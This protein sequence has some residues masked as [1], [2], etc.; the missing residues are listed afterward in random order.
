[1]AG[2]HDDRESRRAHDLASDDA[3]ERP[4][5]PRVAPGKLSRSVAVYGLISRAPDSAAPV[6]PDPQRID[7]AAR[8][9]GQAL[10]DALRGELE[11]SIGA[12]LSAVRV[13]TDA[14]SADAAQSIHAKA[15]TTGSD[16][17]FAPSSYDPDSDAGRRLIAHEVAHTVQQ[18]G[19]PAVQAKL[20]VSQPGDSLELEAD[21]F[22]DAFAAGHVSPVQPSSGA[23]AISRA[24]V[25]G[26]GVLPPEE[27]DPELALYLPPPPA[28]DPLAEPSG[29]G[30]PGPR[31][32]NQLGLSDA[33]M[34]AA[35]TALAPL[36]DAS[37]IDAGNQ[38]GR[39]GQRTSPAGETDAPSTGSGTT[40]GNAP[41]TAETEIAT[42]QVLIDRSVT[43]AKYVRRALQIRIAQGAAAVYGVD[44][45]TTLAYAAL[46]DAASAAGLWQPQHLRVA[47]T[48]APGEGLLR[49]LLEA[50]LRG[51]E[52]TQITMQVQGF[53]SILEWYEQHQI[54]RGQA[55]REFKRQMWS[56]DLPGK[57]LADFGAVHVNGIV[58]GFND[59]AALAYQLNASPLDQGGPPQ[60]PKIGYQTSWGQKYGSSGELGVEL[61]TIWLTGGPLTKAMSKAIPVVATSVGQVSVYGVNIGPYLILAAKTGGVMLAGAELKS[62]YD[63]FTILSGSGSSDE[64]KHA[65]M[66]RIFLAIVGAAAGGSQVQGGRHRPPANQVPEARTVGSSGSSSTRPTPEP[67]PSGRTPDDASSTTGKGSEPVEPSGA[68][69]AHESAEPSVRPRPKPGHVLVDRENIR[70]RR[71]NLDETN[72][73]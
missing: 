66:R 5:R 54:K 56:S 41:K 15:Y 52:S 30:M 32:T 9:S 40:V 62:V 18:T 49:E 2:D 29:D 53:P 58:S 38:E 13:H 39:V 20:E 21:R 57:L 7:A 36:L 63:D 50:E 22:A 33:E 70:S 14:A 16:I 10:P 55:I 44:L 24:P 71:L 64:D 34:S 61:A 73:T 60:I 6:Q 72:G 4:Y 12:D 25:E 28:P 19:A 37:E 43:R 3:P 1:M 47:G 35:M 68:T 26:H 11:Q 27:A 51:R 42:V 67:L 23:G 31:M 8:T 59:L 46:V 45:D 48:S 69:H 65:A 17:Y